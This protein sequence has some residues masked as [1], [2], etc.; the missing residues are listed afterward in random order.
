M[1]FEQF[2]LENAEL[3]LE[4]NV[5][6]VKVPYND[7][8]I[9]NYLNK[10]AQNIGTQQGK[11]FFVKKLSKLLLNAPKWHNDVRQLPPDAPEW[12]HE[13]LKAHNLVYFAPDEDLEDIVSNI[14]HYIAALEQDANQT[15]NRDA[16]VIANRELQSIPKIETLDLFQNK[17]NEYFKRGSKKAGRDVSGLKEVLDAGNGFTW[18]ELI[19]EHAFKREGKALQNCIGTHYTAAKCRAENTRI[20]VLKTPVNETV[21]GLRIKDHNFQEAKGKNNKPPIAKY[22]PY[23]GKFINNFHIRV[24]G[25]QNDLTNAGYIYIENSLLSIPEAIKKH[26]QSKKLFDLSKGMSVHTVI[27]PD[28]ALGHL[29]YKQY[30]ES[31]GTPNSSVYVFEVRDKQDLPRV[32]LVTKNK[33]IINIKRYDTHSLS[34]A[35]NESLIVIREAAETNKPAIVDA[36]Q[37]LIDH[38]YVKGL[39]KRIAGEITW[40]E[41][42]MFNSDNQKF[43]PRKPQSTHSTEASVF[44]KWEKYDETTAPALFKSLD[45]TRWV[46]REEDAE[47]GIKNIYLHTVRKAQHENPDDN[48][49]TMLAGIERENGLLDLLLVNGKGITQ[50]TGVGHKIEAR[51]YF[52]AP[53]V[54][55][56]TR[57]PNIINAIRHLANS[58]DAKLPEQT[59]ARLG[60]IGSQGKYKNVEDVITPEELPGRIPATKYNFANLKPEQRSIAFYGIIRSEEHKGVRPNKDRP[61]DIRD[62]KSDRFDAGAYGGVLNKHN[63]SHNPGKYAA[64]IHDVLQKLTNKEIPD[65][66]IKFDVSYGHGK[67]HPVYVVTKDNKIVAVDAHTSAHGWQHWEDNSLVASQIRSFAQDHGLTFKRGAIAGGSKADL[68]V[69]GGDIMS[70]E[71]A[72]TTKQHA[73]RGKQTTPEGKIEVIPFKDGHKLRRA[74]P[75][76]FATW[77]RKGQQKNIAGEGWVLETSEGNPVALGI[78]HNK[79]LKDFYLNTY[80]KRPTHPDNISDAEPQ[81][82]KNQAKNKY[83][84]WMRE[85]QT[86]QETGLPVKNGLEVSALP[87][88]MAA[89]K[90]LGWSISGEHNKHLNL[91]GSTVEVM[92]RILRRGN[93]GQYRSARG[94]VTRNE[95]KLRVMGLVDFGRTPRGGGVRITV[96]DNGKKALNNPSKWFNE[97]HSSAAI[98]DSF[99]IPKEE[100]NKQKP[101]EKAARTKKQPKTESTNKATQ[102]LNKF[103]EMTDDNDGKMPGRKEFM[104]VL[105][106]EPFNMS[107]AG[108]QTYYYNTKM[109]YMKANDM[110]PESFTFSWFVEFLG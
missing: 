39:D 100:P 106:S 45:P 81:W 3:L 72:L 57:D 20:F 29:L 74:D 40:Q 69:R 46:E 64:P 35:V 85:Q 76:T 101:E 26:V 16:N 41:G 70:A 27:V 25:S 83:N 18:Y 8:S 77:A 73:A 12:A 42:W 65:A 7:V 104:N 6:N 50:N 10:H 13:G 66:L 84:E 61:W 95:E 68:A 2:I 23:V 9:F 53:H 82:R 92:K 71:E 43:N 67:K 80:S 54:D 88:F 89:A 75:E 17:A 30:E 36:I 22:M 5:Y 79:K 47:K 37:Q 24:R 63:D 87:Y 90:K 21:V 96:N 11:D 62:H 110:L 107:K 58:I 14:S 33:E 94:T 44:N 91:S 105:Q 15:Q 52:Q 109:K 51:E 102:A 31:I 48:V 1:D 108:A 28:P 99:S 38:G 98:E 93:R 56:N 103:E 86:M 49:D 55:N 34:S 32:S 60:L 78:V 59:M 19:D 4:A 97:V